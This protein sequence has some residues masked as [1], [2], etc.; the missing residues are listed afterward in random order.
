MLRYFTPLC[1]LCLPASAQQTEIPVS[2][3]VFNNGTSLP[4]NGALGVFSKTIHPGFDVGTYH[5]YKSA[6]KHDFIQTFKLGYFYHQFNQHAMQLYSEFGYRYKTNTGLYAEGL[7][8]AGY[9][10]SFADIQ[11]FKLVDGQYVKK[12]NWGRPQLMATTS[13]ALGYDFQTKKNFPLKA[14]LQYQFWMQ[15]PFVNKYVPL[16]PNA[17]LHV[18]I[19]YIFKKGQDCCHKI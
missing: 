7:I 18:G 9:L 8:G 14:F 13:V 3:S 12:A 19:V 11:Q 6:A 15:A 17:A 10:H 1:F 16:L 5:L 2:L 4:G